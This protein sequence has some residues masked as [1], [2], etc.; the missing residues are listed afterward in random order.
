MSNTQPEGTPVTPPTIDAPIVGETPAQPAA[1]ADAG[2]QGAFSQ[3]YGQAAPSQGQYGQ[4]NYG[5][6]YGQPGYTAQAPFGASTSTQPGVAQKSKL[7]AGLL[8][9]L[10]GSLGIH[11]FYLGNTTKGV[12]QLLMTILSF[13]MLAFVSGLW[14]LIEGVLILISTPGTSWHRDARGVELSD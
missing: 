8:G 2:T 13:G 5:Q 7:V 12:I 14:G 6:Q 3:Q 10:L 1:A 4:P 9:I 11:N